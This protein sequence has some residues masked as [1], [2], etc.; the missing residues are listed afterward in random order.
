MRKT[1]VARRV[2]LIKARRAAGLNQAEMADLLNISASAYGFYE[3]CPA[4]RCKCARID[5]LMAADINRVLGI[6][7]EQ[8][9][10]EEC[11]FQGVLKQEAEE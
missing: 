2:W 11:K 3:T 7:I 4:R 9:V 8:M 10:R 5:L 6:P 1:E